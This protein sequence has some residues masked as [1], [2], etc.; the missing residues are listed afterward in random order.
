MA[1]KQSPN[2]DKTLFKPT[3]DKT[4]EPAADKTVKPGDSEVPGSAT[5]GSGVAADPVV[6]GARPEDTSANTAVVE[7][8]KPEDTSANTAAG[9]TSAVDV[10]P[11]AADSADSAGEATKLEEA[12]VGKEASAGKQTSADTAV[13]QPAAE[14]AKVNSTEQESELTELKSPVGEENTTDTPQT[15]S[16]GALAVDAPKTTPTDAEAMGTPTVPENAKVDAPETKDDDKPGAKVDAP[17]TKDGDKLG[18][19]LAL[20]A[21]ASPAAVPAVTKSSCCSYC[22]AAEA[23]TEIVVQKE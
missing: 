6:E 10:P 8:A 16:L 4:V 3:A 12:S 13:V 1:S 18:E 19:G 7:D 20:E 14:Q 9:E 2:T 21:G 5:G 15:E 22:C 17:K 11:V 23:Q